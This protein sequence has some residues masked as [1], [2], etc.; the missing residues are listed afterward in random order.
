MGGILSELGKKLAEK[1]LSLLVLPGALFLA[2]AMAGHSLGHTHALDLP[3]LAE[4]VSQW[5]RAPVTSTV[6]GQVVLLAAGLGGAAAAAQA[7]GS[8]IERI[9]LAADWRGWAPV[10]RYLADRDTRRRQERWGRAAQQ[11]Q[12]ARRDAARAR[13]AGRGASPTS[14]P[15]EPRQ[16]PR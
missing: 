2:V 12:K 8:I 5:A 9:T 3:Q 13:A 14:K 10:V 6:G 11:W 7:V 4:Y 16:K 15:P 1:W